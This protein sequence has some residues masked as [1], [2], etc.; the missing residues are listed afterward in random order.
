[1]RIA[2]NAE[3]LSEPRTGTGRYVYNLLSALGR[4]DPLVEYDILST[5]ELV[6]RPETP[7][8][9]R[10]KTAP[11]PKLTTQR[12]GLEK[13][14]WE[15]R[16]FPRAAHQ[17]NADLLHVPYFAPPLR[18]SGI[19]SLVTILDVIPQRLPVYRASSTKQFYNQLISRSARRATTIIAISNHGKQDIVDTLGIPADRIS[20][21][22]LAPDPRLR[23]AS[24][25]AQQDLR[26]R[27]RLN[28]PFILNI[29]GMDIRKNI[30]GLIEAFAEVYRQLGNPDLR[31]FIAGNPAKLGSDVIF[32]DWR[33]LAE[34][35]GVTDKLICASVTE[36]DLATLY[37]AADCFV[38]TSLYEGF[39]LTPLEAMA[40]GAPVVCSDMTSLPEVV[41][42][43]GLLVDPLDIR[44]LSAAIL[45]VLRTPALAQEL[46]RK[47]LEQATR[48]TWDR[49]AS[50]TLA[51]YREVMSSA[52][53]NSH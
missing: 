31:L 46:R 3:L 48:F 23:P 4:L 43:A 15:Q 2:F 53:R 49:T 14:Y 51:V 33:P 35:L 50:E 25:E 29:G 26:H 34:E 16:T 22:Y 47:G 6:E 18:T 40:C 32:P 9:M 19:P 17:A 28:G 38:F 20:V 10:W 27:L 39:G 42:E 36:P 24:T 7:P 1:M 30:A 44:A 13:L 52:A 5:H 12:A 21:T 45:E 41:G 37:S 8:S 11:M